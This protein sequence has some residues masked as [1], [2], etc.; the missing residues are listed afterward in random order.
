[1]NDIVQGREPVTA[2]TAAD[3]FDADR[4][5]ATLRALCA[6]DMQGRAPGTAGH[7]LATDFL[8][9]E[10]TSYGLNPVRD[11]FAI[12]EVMRLEAQPALRVTGPRLERTLVHRAEFAE[13]PRS[14]PMTGPAT[15]PVSEDARAGEWAVLHSVPQ[16]NA[17][18]ELADELVKRGA[19]GILTAQNTDASGFLTKRVQGPP[20]VG[21]PVIAIRPDLL[22]EAV[23]GMITAHVPLVRGPATG[24]NVVATFRGSDPE[25]R[26]L[27]LTA[28]YDGVGSDPERHFPC[29]GDNAS[30]TAVLCEV[31]R[32]LSSSQPLS[33]TV[34]FALVDAEEMGTLGSGHHARQLREAGAE[35]DVL[36]L[37]MAGKFNGKVAV[38]LG[39]TDP[40]PRHL[41]AALDSAGKGLRIP[42]YAGTVSSD[43]RRYA[44]AGFP[45]AGI[46]FGAAHYHSPL[47]SPELIDPDAL[48]KAGRLVLET[49]RHL[50]AH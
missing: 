36:N 33:R 15:G 6:P 37:D 18:A 46:G 12:R 3:L 26:P 40:A 25:M 11:A 49:I 1:M 50:A 24:I 48:D 23:G 34:V 45:A 20:P 13:H 21:L 17:F 29:A 27:L 38:E 30:G 5:M 19:M 31:A 39:P 32:V 8:V 42:L 16:G 41:I 44:S 14:A 4:A 9:E 10:L 47:D 22:A 28:H 2:P 7:D 35:P 43:N